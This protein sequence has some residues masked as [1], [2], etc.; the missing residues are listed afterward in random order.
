MGCFV[1]EPRHPPG[2]GLVGGVTAELGTEGSWVRD[3]TAAL[4]TE[5]T[6]R[7]D[8]TE[9]WAQGGPGGRCDGGLGREGCEM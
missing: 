3:G 6:Q 4:R 5:E 9:V 1:G 8:V 2:K 7:G